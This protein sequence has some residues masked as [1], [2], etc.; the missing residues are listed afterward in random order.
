[1]EKEP[2]KLT[3]IVAPMTTTPNRICTKLVHM[4]EITSSTHS[5]TCIQKGNIKHCQNWSN[6]TS[7]VGAGLR[8][9]KTSNCYF[10]LLL[11]WSSKEEINEKY[12]KYTI[13]TLFFM[14]RVK[15]YKSLALTGFH[16]F[17][18]TYF[19]HIYSFYIFLAYSGYLSYPS[20]QSSKTEMLHECKGQVLLNRMR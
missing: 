16:I 12:R 6:K 19:S 10:W 18:Y 1:M 20:S 2:E 14:N 15:I 7:F 8:K 11:N 13:T 5:T 9:K 3:H 4:H 17:I